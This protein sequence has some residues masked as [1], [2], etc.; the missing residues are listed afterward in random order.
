MQRGEGGGLFLVELIHGEAYFW[1]FTVP[2]V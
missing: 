2:Y 1:N